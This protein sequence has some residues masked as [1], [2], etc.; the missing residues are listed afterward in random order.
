MLRGIEKYEAARDAGIFSSHEGTGSVKCP[1]RGYRNG[2]IA[3]AFADGALKD[4]LTGHCKLL[5]QSCDPIVLRGYQSAV[6]TALIANTRWERAHSP[7]AESS[8]LRST[9]PLALID[10]K[11]AMNSMRNDLKY[12]GL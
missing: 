3:I 2:S 1:K 9:A 12:Y 11:C 10:V 6:R 5:F 4:R 8:T 7:S